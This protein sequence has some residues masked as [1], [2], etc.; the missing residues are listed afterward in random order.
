MV[1]LLRQSHRQ[2]A[3]CRCHPRRVR[4]EQKTAPRAFDAFF[5]TLLVGFA[6]GIVLRYVLER[7]PA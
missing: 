6:I 4:Q 7:T 3:A 5:W 1:L 2:A